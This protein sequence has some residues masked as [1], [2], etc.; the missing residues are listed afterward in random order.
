MS[1]STRA[2]IAGV[3]SLALL[4]T[5]IWLATDFKAYAFVMLCVFGL[6]VICFVI[7]AIGNKVIDWVLYGK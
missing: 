5:P 3:V 6:M 2:C 7:M 1:E 4:G